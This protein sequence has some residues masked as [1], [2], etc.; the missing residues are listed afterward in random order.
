[1]ARKTIDIKD[2]VEMVN[3]ILSQSTCSPDV[4]QGAINVLEGILNRTGNYR[5]FYYLGARYVPAGEKPGVNLDSDYE[6]R[7]VDTDRTR[8]FYLL[9]YC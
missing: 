9:G 5:G 1:M 4:R 3:D 7:F 8:V 2:V 6:K